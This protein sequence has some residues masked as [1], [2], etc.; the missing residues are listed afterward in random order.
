MMLIDIDSRRIQYDLIGPTDGPLVCFAHSLSSDSGIWSEQLPPLLTQGWQILRLNMRGHGGSDAGDGPYTMTGLADDVIAVIDALRVAQ[1]HFV[2]VSIGG[3]I[4]QTLGIRHA[5]RL[6]SLM[7]CGTSPRSV[8]GGAPM[9]EA[10]FAAIRAA[11]SLEPLADDTM[12]RWFT[13]AFRSR[14]PD[15]WKQVRETIANTTPDG[16]FGGAA[17][18]IDFDVL[19]A[20]SSVNAPTL[21][22]CGDND[23]GTPPEGNQT[24]ARLIP[25]ARYQ[26]I[27]DARHIPMLEHPERFNQILLDWLNSKR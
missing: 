25:G 3:M 18:I 20:L 7:L 14:R 16:Y 19:A 15:R 6:L 11:G 8:P 22:V 2:G 13:D 21:V 17:A 23:V 4:G 10:R 26:E 12:R 5:H 9:W 27:S 1:M 24:I